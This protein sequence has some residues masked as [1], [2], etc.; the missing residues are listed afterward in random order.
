MLPDQR[1]LETV[2][3]FLDPVEGAALYAAA[4]YA[5]RRG[6]CLEIGSYCGKSAVYIG[7]ACRDN[8]AVLFSIDHHC[9][10]E[11]Q[12]PGEAYCD[13][14]LIE[15]ATGTVDTFGHFR[16][17]LRAFSLEDTVVP[18]VCPS[19]VAARAW[20]TPLAMVFIDGGHAFETV[21]NDFNAWAGHVMGGGVLAIHDVFER[22]EDGGLS[23]YEVY[24]Y[25]LASGLFEEIRQVKSLRLLRRKPCG[26][27]A[28]PRKYAY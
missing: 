23:P 20:A 27:P 24:E 26:A 3:G 7:S 14:D 22:P 19:T 13:P 2:K 16:R 10:S 15:A 6:P 9:G 5:S 1:A 18:M 17:S 11:E 4:L 8:G 28:P 12:Q 21:W 25:A